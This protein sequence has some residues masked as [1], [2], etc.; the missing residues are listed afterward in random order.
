MDY[1]YQRNEVIIQRKTKE[2]FGVGTVVTASSYI[3]LVV[4]FM[5]IGWI[6][7]ADAVA[8][9]ALCD[10]FVD[11][12][13]FP[14]FVLS[15]GGPILAGILLGKRKFS[16]ANQIFTLSLA[17]TIA[18]SLLCWCLLPFCGFF[19][20]A[21]A[22]NGAISNDVARYAFFCLAAAPFVGIELVLSGFAVLDNHS[23]LAM[24]SVVTANVVNIGLDIVFMKVL[25][26]GVAGASLASLVGNAMGIL[27]CLPYLFSKSR[28]FRFELNLSELKDSC[29]QL[30]A[31]STSFAVDKISR[32]VSG[33]IVNVTLVYFVGN[34]GVALYAVYGRL[35]F[36][37]K[38]IA[39]GALQTISTLGSMLYGER[40]F[41]GLRKMMSQLLKYTYSML[42]VLEAVL[43]LF[44]G[45][46]LL[47][48]GIEPLKDTLLAFRIMLL[49]LPIYWLNDILSRFYPSIQRQQLSVTLLAF[50]NVVFRILLLLLGAFAIAKLNLSS[51]PVVA[52]WCFMVELLSL[53]LVTA[54][55]KHKYKDIALIDMK[56]FVAPDCHTFSITGDAKNVADVHRELESF[57][58]KNGISRKKGTLLAIA[59]EE[60]VLYI[61]DQ[62]KNV[63][64]I[65]ICLLLENGCLLVRIRD[66][67]SPFNPLAFVDENDILRLNN[68]NLLERL[69]NQKTYTRIMNMNNTVLSINLEDAGND[70]KGDGDSRNE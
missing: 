34:I 24:G 2:F 7:G 35:K 11:L 26:F 70:G 29:K 48:Y 52:V 16:K 27:V 45:R 36:I 57:C 54:L 69:T 30:L 31:A 3:V 32:I 39:G 59:L 49:S 66:N 19:G 38:I 55:E 53:I 25:D 8:A 60:A 9:A 40:D 14:G 5:L 1:S 41:F 10:S 44:S 37:L 56:D 63:D 51:L 65:D 18:A 46:F 58:F 15:S 33:L 17:I 23:N 22:N 4:D 28:T 12:A 62:N 42:V 47:S 20:R 64:M 43:F 6:L 68:I 61:I 67:G 50:Q 13:E 21:L